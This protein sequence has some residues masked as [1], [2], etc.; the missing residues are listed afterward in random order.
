VRSSSGATGSRLLVL[1][2]AVTAYAVDQ[3]TKQVAVHRLAGRGPVEV[4]GSLLELRLLRNPGAAFSAGTSWTPLITVVAI[5]AAVVVVGF[6][7]RVRHRG[8]AVALGLLL[9]G[10]VGN[11][12]DRLLRAPGPFRGHVVD[13]LA[14]PHWP[15]FNVADMCIDVAGALIVLLLLRGAAV[16][17]S[18]HDVG[19]AP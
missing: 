14:L 5:V 19:E 11:L 18:R 10:I 4:V 7:L 3:V 13:F 15:V 2:V 12:T 16:D 1:V 8:W 6:A 17:G 9:A